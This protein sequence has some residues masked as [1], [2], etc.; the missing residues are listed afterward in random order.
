MFLQT[1]YFYEKRG[2]NSDLDEINEGIGVCIFSRE[3]LV[4]AKLLVS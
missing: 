3:W 2:D 4:I 1:I